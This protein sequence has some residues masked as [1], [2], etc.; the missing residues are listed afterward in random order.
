MPFPDLHE[1]ICD[2]LR[3]DRPAVSMETL[4]ADGEIT[5]YFDDGTLRRVNQRR[6]SHQNQAFPKSA[7]ASARSEMC[8]VGVCILIIIY[9]R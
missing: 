3:G 2:A 1:R 5:G 8:G 9:A 6:N 7:R 4:S